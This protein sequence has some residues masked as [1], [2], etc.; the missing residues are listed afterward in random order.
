MKAF[1]ADSYQLPLPPGHRFP[2]EKYSRLKERLLAEGVIARQDMLVPEPASDEQLLLVHHSDYLQRVKNGDLDPKEIRRIGFPWS[3][4]MV[5]RSRRSVGGTIAACRAALVDG[6][7]A[8]LAGGTHHAYP[9][10]GEGFCVF[11]DVAV[12][13]RVLLA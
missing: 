1:S 11:N 13:A 3:P 4:E 5:E 12:A 10:H 7:A 8:H 2:V 9:D 6:I